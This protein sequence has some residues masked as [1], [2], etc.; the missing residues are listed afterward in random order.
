[1]NL[2]PMIASALFLLLASLATAADTPAPATAA[3]AP[4]PATAED[5]PKLYAQW[6]QHLA[7]F[8]QLRQQ[9]QNDASADRPALEA[10][11]VKLGEQVKVLMPR[12]VDAAEKTYVAAPNTNKEVNDFLVCLI[13][14]ISQGPSSVC[15]P[16][17]TRTPS[18]ATACDFSNRRINTRKCGR[19]SRRFAPKKTPP[20]ICPR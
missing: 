4:A 10:E 15:K 13:P 7:R 20:A 16:P 9:Y 8:A 17:R 1:M 2:R 12:L 18:I 3:A 19:E 11:A 6:K 14:T 5:F